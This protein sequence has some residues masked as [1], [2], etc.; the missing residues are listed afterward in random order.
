M[1]PLINPKLYPTIRDSDTLNK[2]KSKII[3]KIRYSD[4][5]N[6]SKIVSKIVIGDKK[7]NLKI[8]NGGG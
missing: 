7:G 5:F 2:S 6:K 1:T 3:F 8:G 4:A